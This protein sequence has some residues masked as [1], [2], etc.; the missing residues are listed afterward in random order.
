[1]L[2][3][4]KIIG[5]L[6]V[7]RLQGDPGNPCRAPFSNPLGWH[8]DHNCLVDHPGLAPAGINDVPEEMIAGRLGL[9]KQSPQYRLDE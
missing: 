9:Q 6:G 1:M 8:T 7:K 3:L 5:E 2:L 4:C